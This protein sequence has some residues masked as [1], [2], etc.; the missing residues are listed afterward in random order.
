M[1]EC[2]VPTVIK[3]LTCSL[4]LQQRR[5][6]IEVNTVTINF[7]D[8]IGSNVQRANQFAPQSY[9][10]RCSSEH[11]LQYQ[12]VN[13]VY[14]NHLAHSLILGNYTSSNTISIRGYW[15]PF[16]RISLNLGRFLRAYVT[17]VLQ[18]ADYWNITVSWN[19]HEYYLQI[20]HQS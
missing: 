8:T 11:S 1:L 9:I 13:C 18:M 12:I 20:R 4:S 17:Q 2:W 16:W 14:F 10:S 5:R 19:G 3:S 15:Q 6:L 7:T